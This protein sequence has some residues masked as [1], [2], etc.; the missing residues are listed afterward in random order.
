MASSST[1]SG[2]GSGTTRIAYDRQF[3]G[4][5]HL[6]RHDAIRPDDQRR[7]RV[8]AGTGASYI[9]VNR[10]IID[11]K[12]NRWWEGPNREGP[13]NKTVA[14]PQFESQTPSRSG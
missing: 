2:C 10:Q 12:T 7:Q 11:P 13:S 9:N 8:I 5:A 1:G 4:Q 6:Q 3:V 14:V